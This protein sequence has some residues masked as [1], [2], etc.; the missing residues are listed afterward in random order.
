[1][2]LDR[3]GVYVQETLNPVQ[4]IAAPTSATIAAFY[5]AND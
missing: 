5:G 4:T 2:A 3:P 1:M